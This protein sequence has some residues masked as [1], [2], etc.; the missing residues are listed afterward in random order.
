MIVSDA[1][2]AF[3]VYAIP[4]FLTAVI[5]LTAAA[6]LLSKSSSRASAAMVG[7]TLAVAL[8]QGAV[9][10][11][12]LAVNPQTAA[13]WARF[14]YA[15]VPFLAPATYQFV[16]EILRISDRRKFS[17]LLGWLGAAQ[18]AILS[19][20]TDLVPGVRS[21]WWGFYPTYDT[22]A[23]VPYALFFGGYLAV[24]MWELTRAY[25][26]SRGI[27][28][29]RLG[30]FIVA[31][32][33]GYCSA[34]DYLAVYGIAVYPFGYVA[35][36]AYAGV[37]TYAV[38]KYGFQPISPALAANEIISTMRDVLFVCDRDGRIE[39]ANAS[40]CATLGYTASEILGRQLE[41]F[42]VAADH[43][44]PALQRSIRDSD[45]VFRTRSGEKVELTVSRSPVIRD[46][47]TA[48][49][50]LIGRDLRDRKRFER[51]I[52]SANALL[53]TTL[54]S[55]AD[56]I[57]AI[58]ANGEILSWNRRLIDMWRIPRRLLNDAGAADLPAHM[59][60]QLIDP[61]EF[62]GSMQSDIRHDVETTH[63]LE[64]KDGRRFEQYSVGRSTDKA[65][66]RVWSFRD[67]TARRRAEEALRGSEARYRLLFEEN[68][69]GVCVTTMTG[70]IIDC[71]ATFG[72]MVGSHPDDLT[73]RNL[74]ILFDQPTVWEN[75]L[76]RLDHEPVIK[77][78]EAE[79]CR[80]DGTRIWVLKNLAVLGRGPTAV[81]HLTTVD[82]SDR[83][84][85]E[86]Q[87][88]F[89]AYHDLLTQLP[90]RRLLMD[91][92]EMSLLAAKR[93]QRHVAV[94]FID[95]NGFK[96]VNDTFGHAVGDALLR[97][98]ATRLRGVVR[99]TDTV[100]RFG[101]DEFTIMLPD[102]GNPDDAVQVAQKVLD[103]VARSFAVA[104]PPLEI[105]ASVGIAVYPRDGEDL[106]TLLRNADH[107]M[108]RAKE[109]R[110]NAYQLSV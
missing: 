110:G 37:A 46:G 73:R 84:R 105:S 4:P 80:N 2:Y 49:S 55:T 87:I 33:V 77:G 17:T 57:L 104:G 32:A 78:A 6:R 62:L 71:N 109:L 35:L 19:L 28:R 12:I 8:W 76:R 16:V 96:N 72:A 42:I 85:A 59:A 83:K 65:S 25:P 31:L 30:L 95:L 99:R 63:L 11:M 102:L 27:E 50:V 107:A 53:Q 23:S 56:G 3:S 51:D 79:L 52:Q 41:D 103:E 82:I 13:A 98:F 67:V 74:A 100:A 14:G 26:R 20:T 106:D 36:L 9:A 94:L 108:Y 21:Y 15:C 39:F 1:M 47:E 29:K 101:G 91:R 38:A 75:V 93:A 92:L 34:L 24:A 58:G 70:E 48:G 45:H 60:D 88:E 97:E 89:H 10:M 86:E 64:R 22:A 81:V 90:N 43:N 40:A 18:F 68:A 66:L 61:A 54:E 5:V 44:D 69:A 7:M